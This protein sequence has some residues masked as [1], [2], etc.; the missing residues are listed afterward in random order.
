MELQ[1]AWRAMSPSTHEVK[2]WQL[3]FIIIIIMLN[4][5]K[6]PITTRY[7][8]PAHNVQETYRHPLLSNHTAFLTAHSFPVTVNYKQ[9][10]WVGSY[11]PP[12]QC[13]A[14]LTVRQFVSN[15]TWCHQS[16]FISCQTWP[17]VQSYNIQCFCL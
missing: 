17:Q 14:T 2:S 4:N 3:V 5:N 15:W 13:Y 1:F 11:D 12:F 16:V 7:Y 9:N 10:P 8:L 6:N